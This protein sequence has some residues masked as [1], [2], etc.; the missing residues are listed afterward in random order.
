ML[1]SFSK[2]IDQIHNTIVLFSTKETDFHYTN[3]ISGENGKFHVKNPGRVGLRQPPGAQSIN[4][5]PITHPLRPV[6]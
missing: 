2:K 5:L 3:A 4:Q 1:S 6:C